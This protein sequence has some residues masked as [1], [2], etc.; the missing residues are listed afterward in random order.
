LSGDVP[1]NSLL[2]D[3]HFAAEELEA[4]QQGY[5]LLT[6][7]KAEEETED[8]GMAGCGDRAAISSQRVEKGNQF[9]MIHI[10]L[11]VGHLFFVD[12][13]FLYCADASASERVP[14][15]SPAKD[16]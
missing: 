7:E 16:P 9:P 15:R 5:K 14:T 4:I 3:S 8:P 1:T 2:V 6:E 12:N 11:Y 10:S 13:P